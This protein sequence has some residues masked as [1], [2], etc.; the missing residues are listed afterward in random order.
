[1]VPDGIMVFAAG[2]GTRMRP[3]TDRVPKA[4][5]RIAGKP[6]LDHALDQARD[7]GLSKIVVNAHHLA[8]QIEAHVSGMADVRLVRERP[9]I[10]D[11]GG[12]LR[13]AL[14]FLGTDPVYTMNSDYV[15]SG[16]NPLRQLGEAWDPARMDGL[17][18]MLP[19]NRATG[20]RGPG[21]LCLARDGR[22]EPPGRNGQPVMVY[23]GA[24]I[25]RTE[26]LTEIRDEAF[27]VSLLWS[28]M[29]ARNRLFGAVYTGA[30][31]EVG[32][33][34]AMDLAEAML[35]ENRVAGGSVDRV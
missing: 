19:A 24:Q 11:T 16:P 17:M 34:E 26:G 7:A 29:S 30:W 10:L 12:G 4:M 13:N 2:F 20:Y 14:P 27:S 15:W 18:L 9:R 1:M 22:L 8:D 28:R 21:D 25:I 23:A 6:L 5:I 32:H 3:M 31:A 35:E 33:P